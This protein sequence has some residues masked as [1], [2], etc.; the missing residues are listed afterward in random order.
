MST[1]PKPNSKPT[2]EQQFRALLD[3]TLDSGPY[4]NTDKLKHSLWC[5]G[6]LSELLTRSCSIEVRNHLHNTLDK[7][8]GH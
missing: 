1:A 7:H 8:Q 2:E 6:F 4:A 3:R 5:M